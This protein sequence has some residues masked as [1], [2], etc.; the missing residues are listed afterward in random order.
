MS[1]TIWLAIGVLFMIV[2]IIT[3]GFLFLSF[4]IG[5]ILTGLAALLFTGLPTQLVIFAI[6]TTISFLLMRRFASLLLKPNE[7]EQ[8]NIYALIGKTGVVKKTIYPH[9]KGYVK[10]EGEEWSAISENPDE[11]IEEETLVKVLKLEGNKVI[12]ERNVF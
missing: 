9:K 3:P 2:E 10:I 5:A 8:S 6:T 7:A 1:W 4:G 11:T 12:V